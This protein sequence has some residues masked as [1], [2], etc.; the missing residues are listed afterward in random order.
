MRG[1]VLVNLHGMPIFI[2][3]AAMLVMNMGSEMVYILEQRLKAQ[4]VST[5]TP[6]T[7]IGKQLEPEGCTGAVI[8]GSDLQFK[9]SC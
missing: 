7:G 9:I 1:R 6:S 5:E 8:P 3:I 4:S 2:Y